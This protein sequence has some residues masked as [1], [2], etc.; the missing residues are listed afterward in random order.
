METKDLIKYDQLSPFEVKDK[1]I[2]LA[3]SYHER[4]M[5]DAG[6]VS[7]VPEV[8]LIDSIAALTHV[9]GLDPRVLVAEPA[10]GRDQDDAATWWTCTSCW[11]N[12]M[13]MPSLSKRIFTCQVMSQQTPL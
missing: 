7:L 10:A 2:E 1:L 12:G 4:M 3:Q 5:L 6:R 9:H 11:G 8:G 13:L